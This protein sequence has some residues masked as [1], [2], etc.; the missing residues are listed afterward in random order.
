MSR[1]HNRIVLAAG[2]T[3]ALITAMAGPD[4]ARASAG[5]QASTQIPV[6]VTGD[7][8]WTQDE[9]PPGFT[10]DDIQ[11]GIFHI[12]LTNVTDFGLVVGGNSSTY[13]ITDSTNLAI[14]DPSGC[15]VNVTGSFSGTGSLPDQSGLSENTGL[16]I[17]IGI[18]SPNIPVGLRII[19]AY[20]EPFTNTSDCGENTTA[21]T[22]EV[23]IPGCPRSLGGA[24]QGTLPNG[25]VDLGCSGTFAGHSGSGS[26]SLKGTLTITPSCGG[27]AAASSCGPPIAAFTAKDSGTTI[28]DAGTVTFNGGGSQPAGSPLTSYAWD[29]G[30]GTRET[31]TSPTVVH[32]YTHIQQYTASLVV[33]D[34]QGNSSDPVSQTFTPDGCN[35]E[36]SATANLPPVDESYSNLIKQIRFGYGALALTF[37][38]TN[39]PSGG[40][41]ADSL[42]SWQAVGTLPMTIAL[43][44]L[45][46]PSI[47][48]TVGLLASATLDF[49]TPGSPAPPDCNWITVK[50]G[51]VIGG[52]GDGIVR[53]HTDGFRVITGALPLKTS[54]AFT[55]YE[56]VPSTDTYAQ[57]IQ[58]LE[59]DLHVTLTQH[60]GWINPLYA[61]QE[62]PADVAVTDSLGNVT[63]VSQAG[64]QPLQQIPG[65]IYV[66]NGQGYSAVL[67]F[68]PAGAYTVT[69]VGSTGSPYSL[70][71][72]KIDPFNVGP[73]QT[74]DVRMTG[75]LTKSG[76]ASACYDALQGCQSSL[77]FQG[78]TLPPSA[79]AGNAVPVRIAVGD[80][81]GSPAAGLAPQLDLAPVQAGKVGAFVPA[82]SVGNANQGNV[83]REIAPGRYMYNLDTK[84]LTPGTWVLR[85]RLSDGGTYTSSFVAR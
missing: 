14:T 64:A 71:L 69:A 78:Y 41:P 4:S 72:S 13:S 7:I 21:P 9:T 51:C 22:P 76:Q 59:P 65:S 11:T 66:T 85:T 55:Y 48:L 49:L 53:W 47:E 30:D 68:Q 2:I 33:T 61:I 80:A 28:A 44:P 25:T 10:G 77:V 35:G 16:T 42:C 81:S 84:P 79:A 73:G 60:L 40:L 70:S 24:F 34:A 52:S 39:S 62:P 43:G 15:N 32:R 36:T 58:A 5:G 17:G 19:I 26:F 1:R 50:T 29:F 46:G 3:V 37:G 75:T 63:G 20:V 31:T 27:G 23:T 6:N 8:A 56:R 12:G 54:P 67:L 38:S 83:F 45:L 18:P 57:A 82:T 74:T